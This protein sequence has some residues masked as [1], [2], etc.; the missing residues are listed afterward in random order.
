MTH[1]PEPLADPP[2]PSPP[3]KPSPAMLIAAVAAH[4]TTGFAVLALLAIAAFFAF[5]APR[6]TDIFADFDTELPAVTSAVIAFSGPITG[7]LIA[8]A[9]LGL[10]LFAIVFRNRPGLV[11][12]ASIFA[13]LAALLAGAIAAL[14]L[15]LP[16]VKLTQSV[17]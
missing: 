3:Q 6:F 12:A 8:V 15:F 1:T 11:A 7:L 4:A 14:A 17:M 2:Q 9:A 10:A 13:L 16:M 5:V